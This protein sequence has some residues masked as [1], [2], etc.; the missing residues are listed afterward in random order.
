M[1]AVDIATPFYS[2]WMDITA[3]HQ[4]L[5]WVPRVGLR[6]LIEQAWA[7]ERPKNDPRKVWYPG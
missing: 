3:A 7:W 1:R 6:E 5:G 2:N 4:A